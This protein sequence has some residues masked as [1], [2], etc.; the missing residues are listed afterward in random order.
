MRNVHITGIM[1]EVRIDYADPD[2]WSRH[3]ELM[4]AALDAIAAPTVTHVFAS[5]PYCE[6][7]ARRFDAKPVTLDLPRTLVPVSGTRVREAP[8]AYWEHLSPPVRAGL[9]LRV[10][11]L[12]AESSGTTTLARDLAKFWRGQGGALGLTRYVAEYGRE[13]TVKKWARARARAIANGKPPPELADLV[14]T[15]DE[16]VHIATEQAAQENAAA[17]AGGPLLI[18]DTNALATAVWHERYLD[19]WR[20]DIAQAANVVKY[21]LY[22]LT[23]HQDIPFEQDGLRD[24]EHKRAW[25]T[26]RF[27]QVLA[28]QDAPYLLLSGSR[29][30]RLVQAL[31]ATHELLKNGWK[32]EPPMQEGEP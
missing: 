11:I 23:D 31:K 7:L 24:G 10:V 25:M 2:I 16:F 28:A 17:A 30:G 18:C 12:G 13:Y 22:L 29:E 27:Q 26:E 15:S 4:R 1:D 8:L 5:E 32:F 21:S 20:E 6:E 9:A 19:E 14:W 3:V